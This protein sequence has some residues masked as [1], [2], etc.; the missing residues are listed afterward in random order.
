MERTPEAVAAVFQGESLTYRELNEKANRLAHHMRALGIGAEDRV[1]FCLERSPRLLVA[2][3]AVMKSG[4]TYVPL[5]PKHP[6]ERL[7]YVL[8][9]TRAAVLLTES[10]VADLLEGLLPE[11]T[12][13]V[14]LDRDH[15]E[16]AAAS[17][18]NPV[19]LP[20]PAERL[21]YIIYT[22]GST[23][24]PKGVQVPHR[25]LVNFLESMG[26]SPG[27]SPEDTLLA[28]TTLSFDMA[29]PEVLLP[30]VT[31]GRIAIA[32]AEVVADGKALAA[33]LES[34]GATVLQAT[35]TTW[36]LLMEAGWEGTPGLRG[37]IGAEAVLR[38]VAD[39]ILDR[40]VE[41]W[42]FYGPTETTVWSTFTR[43]ERA[44]GTVPLGDP[45]AN[46]QVYVLD[47][48]LHQVP[49]GVPGELYIG[50]AG[51]TRGYFGQPGLTAERYLP[52]P[53]TSAQG[54]RLYRT[55]D[56]VRRRS[57]GTLE[58][59][60]RT[61]FQVKIRGFRIEL[62]EIEAVLSSHPGVSQAAVIVR[63]DDP[64]GQRLVAY[65]VPAG[66]VSAG[67]LRD[68]LRGHLEARLPGYMVPS[69]FVALE[70]LPL[71]PNGKVDR[72]AL[73]ALGSAVPLG[74]EFVA[75]RTPAEEL[76]AALWVPLLSVAQVGAHDDFFRLGGHSLLAT[77]LVS[78]IR[79]TFGVELALRRIFERPVL[80]DLAVEIERGGRGQDVPPLVPAG[81][82][83]SGENDLPLSFAQERLWF[84]DQFQPGSAAYNMPAAVRLRGDLDVP[85]FR[86]SLREV[87]RR[88]ESLRTT[89]GVGGGGNG[90][91]V[92]VIAAEPRLEIP[93]VDLRA[94]PAAQRE[95]TVRRLAAEEAGYSFDLAEGPLLRV[96]LLRGDGEWIVLLTMHH[97]VSD[98]WSVNVLIREIAALYGAF[99]AGRPSP[100]AELP[101]QYADFAQWQ[102]GWLA[103]EVLE[104]QIEY[105]RRRLRGAPPLLELP[106][107]RP[108]PAVQSQ[109]GRQHPWAVPADVGEALAALCRSEGATLFMGL[110]A[111]FQGLLQRYTGREDV[112]VG[113]PVAGRNRLE[114]EGLIGLF[115]NSL[116]LRVDLSGNPDFG[117]RLARTRE[118]TLGAYAHQ[119]VPFEKLVQELAPERNMSHSPLFQVMLVLQN[120]PDEPL[121]MAGMTLEPVVAGEDGIEEDIA[122]KLDLTLSMTKTP[123]GLA[124][125]V[126][127]N[128]D[129]FDAATLSRLLGHFEV[130]LRGMVE[131]PD[132]SPLELPLLTAAE[133]AQ[134]LEWNDTVVS[135]PEDIPVHRLF[136][137]RV[138][139]AP[140]R[141]AVVFQEAALTYR[142]LNERAN[143][144]AHAL[145]SGG[146]G[147]E[148]RVGICVERSLEMVVAVLGV[149]KAGGAYVPLDPSHPRERLAWVLRDAGARVLLT[150][151]GVAQRLP[152]LLGEVERVI[153]L[154]GD[155]EEISRFPAENPAGLPL[156]QGL[157]YVIYT[158]G[159]TGQPKG[160]QIPHRALVNFLASMARRP[161]LTEDDAVLAVTTL[162]FDIAGLE[163]LLPLLAGGRVIVAPA[164][165]TGDGVALARLL[166]DSGATV[167]QATPATWR[168]LLES[169]WEGEPDLRVLCGG[170]ALPR[171]LAG[172]LLDKVE[173]LWN[174]YGPTETTVWS[175]AGLVERGEGPVPLGA[176]IA[177]T[178]LH[179]LDA[180]GQPVPA[181]VPGE[182]FIGGDGLAR[183][184]LGRPALTAER[185]VPDPFASARGT[186]G[187]RMYR[188]GDLVRRRAG[189][190][191]E[192]LG[193]TDF[194]VKIRGFRI[195]LG[196]VEAVLAALPGVREAVVVVRSDGSVRSDRSS[197]GQRLVAYVVG[198]VSAGELRGHVE[199]YLPGYMV[200][201]VF[202]TLEALPL[203]PNGKVDRKALP[204]PDDGALV[205]A[206]SYV[207]PR[208]PTEEKLA[209][210]W[211]GLLSRRPGAGDDFFRIG[212]HSLL[213]TQLVS[214]IREGFGIELPLRQVFERPTLEALALEIEAITGGVTGGGAGGEAAPPLRPV[215]REGDL[216]LSFAQ[217]RLWFLDQLQPGSHAYNMPAAVRLHGRLDTGAFLSTLR[218]IAR[219]HE[220]LRTRFA[221]RGGRT[222]QVIAAEPDLEMPV[223]DLRALPA[224]WREAAVRLLAEE[225]RRRTFDLAAGP[226]IR[227]TLLRLGE[228]EHAGLLTLHHIVSDGWS[229]G[230][231]IREIAALYT[232][233]TTGR[234]SPLPELPIQYA[235]FAVWQRE[236][237][238]GEVLEA[239]LAWWRRVLAGHSTLQLP[240]DRPR[241]AIQR[242]NGAAERLA[243]GRVA[244]QA[245]L[246]L[247]ARQ[248]LTSYMTMLAGF[249][250]LLYR[251]SEQDD[252]VIGATVAGRDRGE[253]EP[254]I[255][256]FVNTLP[257][258]AVLSGRPS[259]RELFA[260]VRETTLGALSHQHL[261][262]EKL[263][264]ELAPA[265]G[266]SR[267][268]IFQV[269]FQLHNDGAESLELPG[270]VLSPVEAG[271]QTAKFDIVLNLQET[272][273][274]LQG[275]WSYN[276]DLF[277]RATLARMSGHFETLIAG[278]VAHPDSPVAELPLL[279]GAER[280][281][282]DTLPVTAHGKVDI[283]ADLASRLGSLSPSKRELLLRRL[284]ERPTSGRADRI[285]PVPRP[286]P[287]GEAGLPLSF[288]QQRLW[289][290][291][292]LQPGSAAYNVPAA[293]RL[294]GRLDVAA[295]YRT[296]REIVRRHEVLRTSFAVQAGQP[297][298]V[299]APAVELPLFVADLSGLAPDR[300]EA[301]LQ[302]LSVEE[303]VL[304]FDLRRAPLLR[305]TLARL[306]EGEHTLLLTLHH[307]ISDGW[308]FGVLVREMAALYRAF[309]KGEPSPLPELPVQYAD[310]AV[311]Q[312][313]WL[314]GEVLETQ[315][316][317][318]RDRLVQAPVLQLATDRPR[319]ALASYRGA[320]R[321][322]ALAAG[323]SEALRALSREQGATPFMTFLAGF[324]ALLHRYTS[325]DDLIVGSTIANRVRRELE[326]LIG[327]F[328][329]SLALRTDL[330]GDPSF[331]G[332]VVRAREVALGAYAHQD[333]PFEKLVADLQPERDQSRSPLFQVLCQLQ[334][335]PLGP[336]EL[337]AL[338]MTPMAVSV[339]TA[340]FDLVLNL[341]EEGPVFKG[342]LRYDTGLFQ[343]PTA[344]RIVRHLEAL[345]AGA[346]AEPSR[347]LSELALLSPAERQQLVLEW[348]EAPAERLG[349]VPLHEL[350][351]LQAARAPETVAV[352]SDG[353]R[354]SYGELDRRANRLAWHLAG[355]GVCPGDLVGLCLERSLDMV[356][357]ILGVLKA[358]GAYVPL[359]PTYPRERLAFLLE[360]SR[361]PVLLAQESL[362][363][364]LPEPCPGTRVVFL[365]RIAGESAEPPAIAVSA[366][367]PAYVIYTSGS[368][369]KPK[370][371]VVRHGNVTRL[372]SATDPWFGFGPEDV[373]T[374]FHSYAFDFSVWEIWGALLYGGRLVVVPWA[375]SRSPE[376]FYELL[377]AER[378]TVLNQTPSAFRQLIWAE[379]SAL[380]GNAPDLALRYVIFGGEAL[381]PASLALWFERHG[382]E[383]PRLINMYG[384][385]ETTVH[386]TWRPIER[387]D[388]NGSGSVIGRAIPDLGL[389][390]LDGAFQPQ[391]VGVP[392]EIH[393]GGAGLALGYL[394][395]PELTAERFV[396]NPF[397]EPGSR[398]YRS[399][400]LARRLADGDLEYLGRID[401]Q[402]KIRGFRIELG[403]IESA[404]A[405]LPVVR[406][407]VVLARSDGSVR[408]DRSD[409]SPGERQLVAYVVA[410]G[411]APGLT[412]LRS[413]LAGILPDYMLPSALV[414]LDALPVTAHGKVDRRA[415]PSPAVERPDL[416]GYVAPR[417]TLESF[418][419]GLWQ[420]VLGLTRIGVR[421]DFFGL[422]GNSISGAVL[423][424]RLQQ[425]LAEI[426]HVVVIFDHP[427]VESLATYLAEQHGAAVIRRLGPDA[428]AL[429]LAAA[430]RSERI[431]EDDLARFRAL[432]TPLAPLA[433]REKNRRAVF[434][435]SPPRSGSTLLRVMLGGHPKLFAPPELEL[436]GF[437]TLAERRAA[438]PGRDSFWLE[439]AIRAVMEIHGCGPEEA[440]ER[441]E[442]LERQGLTTASFY[443]RLQD[444]L[445]DLGDLGDRILVDKTP[446]Y[447]LD[448]RV[449]RRAEEIFAEPFYIHLIRHPYGM[450]RSFEE[451]RLDQLFFRR[452]H[453][454]SRRELA[455]LIWLASHENIEAFLREIPASRQHW[456]RFEE[457]VADPEGAL[458]GLCASLG[459]EY[460]PDMAE[461]YTER[462][463]RMTDGLHA[464]SRML[465][466]VKFHQHSGVDRETA[467][468]WRERY[469]ED[470]LGDL[471]WE[472]AGRLGY[473][474]E[475]FQ[476]TKALEVPPLVRAGREGTLP[477]SFAQ[478][479]LWFL[480]QLDPGSPAYNI[481][482]ALR[483]EGRLEIAALEATLGEVVRRHEVLRTT[484]AF[485]DDGREP[486][487]VIHPPRSAGLSVTDLSGL[488]G[489]DREAA[490]MRLALDDLRQPF[491]LD[492]GPLLR[493]TLLRLGEQEHI[494]LFSM[495]H[496]VSDG[497]SMG[498]LV[499][500][501]GN[502]YR[503][504][505]LGQA[506]PLRELPIQYADYAVWQRSWLRGEVLAE[507]VAYWRERLAGAPA[508]LRL[509]ADR[510]RPAVQ[511]FRGKRVDAWLPRELQ[512]ALRT[513][514]Q[515]QGAT[516]FMALLAA[517]AILLRRHTGEDD[518][519][520]GTPTA[521]RDRAEL[522]GLIGFFVNTLPLRVALSG[523]PSFED[524]LSR[525]RE[526]AVGA[527]FHQGVPFEKLVEE[528]Q[529][530]RSLSHSPLF[531]VMLVLQNAPAV[532][533]ELPALTLRAED[534]PQEI[535][536]FDLT[537]TVNET[538]AGLLCQWQY[539]SE[540]FDPAT[541][542]RMAE[543]MRLVVE[544]VA[545]EPGR[546]ISEIPLLTS[547]ER[548]QLLED[549][550]RGEAVQPG[551]RGLHEMVEAQAERRPEAPAV[552][553]DGGELSYAELNGRS[554]R[555]ARRLRRLGVGPEV[556]VGLCAERSPELVVGLIAVLK[557]GGAYVPLD[558]AYP[559]ERLAWLLEDS[560]VPVLL[561]QEHR[562]ADLPPH[563]AQVV[564]L[565]E[566]PLESAHNLRFV[567]V[568]EHLA[569]MIYTSGSTG[570]PKGVLVSHRGLDNLAEAQ[571]RLF[572]V[573]PDSRVLQFASLSFD[574]SVSELAMAFHAGA[575]LCLAPR[576]ELLPGLELIE[577]LRRERIT[578]VTL[579]PSVLAALPEA[580]LPDLRT[581]VVAGEAC[582][583]DLARR[584]SAGRRLINAYG[585]TEVTVCATAGLYDGGGRLPVGRPIQNVEAYVIDPEGHLSL[586]GVPG[587]LLVGGAGLARGYRGRPG[588]TAERFVPHPFSQ[589][590]GERL[591]RT[592]DLVR[593]L[594][595]GD[596]GELEFLGRIDHQ[597]KVRGVRV[598]PGEVEAA[599][600]AQPG[601]REAVAVAR[602][603][604]AGPVRLVAYVVPAA[605]ASL[606]PAALRNALAGT[607]PEPLVPA[608]VAVLEALP[609]TPSGKV[610]RQALPAPDGTRGEAG[611]YV[612]PRTDLER[613]LAGLW[614]EVL[615]A[616]RVG[617]H[618][619]FF[620][621]GGNSITGAMFV[622]RLQRELGEIVHVVVMFDAPTVGQLA[623]WVVENY[624]EA[625]V[626]LFGPEALGEAHR[627]AGTAR[628]DAARVAAFRA[629][630]PP[631]LPLSG[632]VE[633]NPPAVFV[634]SPPRSG[635]T[636]LRVLLGGNPRLFAPPEL[637]LLPFDTLAER[638]AAFPGRDSFWL[639]GVT[640]AVMEVMEVM[641]VRGCTAEEAEAL[642]EEME[643]GGGTTRELYRRLQSWIGERTLVDKTPSYA[644]DLAVLRRAEETFENAR[645]IHLLRHPYGMIRSFE[646]AKLE[647]VFF[648]HPHSLSRRELAELIWLVSQQNILGFL[649]EV[650][651]ERQTRVRFE[652]LL[653]EP[654]AV[655]RGLSDFLGVEYHPDMAAPYKET[656]ARMTDGIHSWSRM[657]GDVKFHQHAGIDPAVG[658]RWR[659]LAAED[660]LGD[661]TWEM[662]ERLGYLRELS[663][664]RERPGSGEAGEIPRLPRDG[665][666]FPASASQ[667]REWVLDRLQP[668]TGAYNIRG[669]GKVVG[670]AGLAVLERSLQEIVRRHE[671][672]RTTFTV[673]ADGEPVQ[674][675]APELRISVPVVDL[676]AL[677]EEPRQAEARRV[678][679]I[680]WN[681]PFDL[682]R[683]PLMRVKIVRLSGREHLLLITFHHI[684]SDGWSTMILYRE[685]AALYEA[686][687][688]GKPSPLPEL[689]IQYADFAA[690]QRRRL[691]GEGLAKQVDYWRR[692]LAGVPPLELPTDR[693]RPPVQRFEGGRV[694]FHL[695]PEPAAGLRAIAQGQGQRQGASL[696][697]ALL[698]AYAALLG[699]YSGQDD[700]SVGSY[701]GNRGRTELEGLIGFF[702]NS[703]VLRLKLAGGPGFRQLLDRAR[704]VTLGAFAHQEVPF[705]KLLEALRVE[706]DL[707]RTPL[708]QVMLVLHNFPRAALDLGG[709]RLETIP[710]DQGRADFDLTLWLLE[711]GAGGLDGAFTYSA[712]LFEEATIARLGGHLATLI[713]AALAEPD[714]SVHELPLLGDGER[715]QILTEWSVGPA[716]GERE[717]CL[718]ELFE[719]QARRAP[720]AIAVEHGGETLTYEELNRRADRLAAHLRGLGV[721]PEVLAGLAV[722]RSPEMVV[723]M[724]AV[725]KAGG[726]YLPLDPAYPE[727]RRA[728]M[729]E[730]SRA[731]VVLTAGK[732]SKDTK[733]GESSISLLSLRSLASFGSL[734]SPQPAQPA[735]TAYVIYTSGSTG[736]PKGVVVE[737]R[738][739]AAYT[740]GAAAAFG[741][742]REDRVLQFA[743]I[744]FDTSGE[745]IY[746]TL[747][748]GAT[749][750]LRPEDMALSIAHFL[751]EVARLRITVLDL[752]TAYWHELAAGLGREGTL[753]DCVRL[754]ILGGEKALPDR[755]ALW[756]EKVGPGV[757]LLNTYGPTEATIV[758]SRCDLTRG[759]VEAPIGRPIPGARAFVLD[760]GGEPVPAG[761]PGELYIGGSGLARG[762]L[763][764]PEITAERF[765]PDPFA[766]A[767]GERLYRTGDRVRW[768]PDGELEF[769]GRVDHQVKLRGFRVEPGEIEAALRGHPAVHDAAVVLK[770]GP[771]GDPRLV[772]Y[773]VRERTADAP[774]DLKAYLRERLPEFMVPALFVELPALPLTPSGKVDRRA[775]PEPAAARPEAAAYVA[776][777]SELERTIAAVWRDLLGVDRIGVED[778]FFDLG[779]HS[780]LLVRAHA[781]L[782]EALGQELTV[783]DL[784]RHPSVGA[785]ARHLLSQ[786]ERPSFHQVEDLM[787]RQ[788]AGL[789]QRQQALKKLKVMTRGGAKR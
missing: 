659:E 231:L 331:S 787:Q 553:F 718:H 531:Q 560:G 786:E 79:E 515:R 652:E 203:T 54:A 324:A 347:R 533:L 106:T 542:E 160:V 634:L 318:W 355:L 502:L 244:S 662:A 48:A 380:G 375:V 421:D 138:E 494:L 65:V 655:L 463:A 438:F 641:E 657:L 567:N 638:R 493:A 448:P 172:R 73:P 444:W 554:N 547:A 164:E 113:T 754:V 640:R 409:G 512:A 181:G 122:V 278:A 563:G 7:A 202:V 323:T 505:V 673:G 524:L 716:T 35:P 152:D 473:G 23:G 575:A 738:S 262:F 277:E 329:N 633:K 602:E 670:P 111:A 411:A 768:R 243:F 546:R 227:A 291:D 407:A 601:V 294:S 84:L 651:P 510:P 348:N 504:S 97:I 134:L 400:D 373:W 483:L 107:D 396:P 705:E 582:S 539:N 334:N 363:E 361:V 474:R 280:Q 128:R 82:P 383:S 521:N 171:E 47:R 250:A 615:G 344:A 645:Y 450:I 481:S 30:L 17:P 307:I 606:D 27:L 259:F 528:L 596:L 410:E 89:F 206:A 429:D 646:E 760:R 157:A 115:L 517:F 566:V 758:A 205:S 649:A 46:T 658:E 296:L 433:L 698:A 267:S 337:P 368:T 25:A 623:A 193:R 266:L 308:S 314:Q 451:A 664:P 529:P 425:E 557:A 780:L 501:V 397:G 200:P 611:E 404:L 289:F 746:P 736:K 456:V 742:G 72:K 252:V 19:P 532:A 770:P 311:W 437:G 45:F 699:R 64:A 672:L 726:A 472:L 482:V 618:D 221:V 687:M 352:I 464:E 616:G 105:W 593:F 570:T 568:P 382:D 548:L 583:V 124:G 98:G 690:W 159:S 315:L 52:D 747:A 744:S 283:P 470:F 398:L 668:G 660:F 627:Q 351:A 756:R 185:F 217:Q 647:Q 327:F 769:L 191:L 711:D 629:L 349:G 149:L 312:R 366:E 788:R 10:R 139:Q 537:L 75:P 102:R 220:S 559:R 99:V 151:D 487:Q 365:D 497:W 284:L 761:V 269:V 350:F 335:A 766:G 412:D 258:R 216:P 374:L 80:A 88:H 523:H 272:A 125:G 233:F 573:G 340:K 58:F 395:R 491:D 434:V 156:P 306:E 683:G 270:L 18:K 635:S 703:Q 208:T 695:P 686:F 167:M 453:P 561:T 95:R 257:M 667:L 376:A 1:G 301:E 599:L 295:L 503:A 576:R 684:I 130:L 388:V 728:L 276:T 552:I 469:R 435:L 184:Y 179:L 67:D 326:G 591:Y 39:R 440:R 136:E 28:I 604:G 319:T 131:R 265:R 741:L 175:T 392:G 745:E 753:P 165:V 370:G 121:D 743:S 577:L 613:F 310:F 679:G 255:G 622:N 109:R 719:E 639:E 154:D 625:V 543:R 153:R 595:G 751:R 739:I 176:P 704:E 782:R 446:S 218:E 264:E 309:V 605:G 722:E 685:L 169:G 141:T 242:F 389:Y 579:P 177:N 708:F 637:E 748:S 182:L 144:L 66:S 108:R 717:R 330:S 321:P 245:F 186:P 120:A 251:Y 721:G 428:A 442:E 642:L 133:E 15:E 303:S 371:V 247:G 379:E 132:L 51:V 417:D 333:L 148:E 418:V 90:R 581:I 29:V 632:P 399:G 710:V 207:A 697:M 488:P 586:P 549:W 26:R 358:G 219:R 544:G 357:A 661:V 514:G 597:I 677:A 509:P 585:P 359:D 387:Q 60:G 341:W 263:V 195:E 643:R 731:A 416:E 689:P 119:D 127:Y 49:A 460:H 436:L 126:E 116:V 752:P 619:N 50:G 776:P 653:A 476:I 110:M 87:V 3:L 78:R 458:R 146:F 293:V 166:K 11:S 273:G 254:L 772:A 498:V 534:R 300:R 617:V 426:V 201:S 211:A 445:G 624:P 62:G 702:I 447:A 158:S 253:L 441:M 674:V 5:D 715:R 449:L 40:G 424:N 676:S 680:E 249:Q 161:G 2:V 150:G 630:I 707:S 325:Q 209:E 34:S 506:A 381:E 343:A 83:V 466:D 228:D 526:T 77:Q 462:S 631:P 143:R 199:T 377:R 268:P 522:E 194:Q 692:Q 235:D 603:D 401:H 100:L 223:V 53:F 468:R 712:A 44:E 669:G 621:L 261:P 338:A 43:V 234:P 511:R 551:T 415:L 112:I 492:C 198:N 666:H 168:L 720:A 789:G 781:R 414:L 774:A 656:S 147:A 671:S 93:E 737:H 24:R 170:E 163:L 91:P 454:F 713:G 477:L 225:E 500:E 86:R 740:A 459:I 478:Q 538:P 36:R 345:L 42:T 367:H 287:W 212:G 360:D 117:Q 587:E 224:E 162:S 12:A 507:Q 771:G 636:L 274:G 336:V 155:R 508:L 479:R 260:Q 20:D 256:F 765:V 285:P 516:L 173:S 353:E 94:L 530:E 556:L 565:D 137:E 394:E 320:T 204:A 730:D 16:I 578:T 305:A 714:R 92:Q 723:A 178:R 183:S 431:G 735:N 85:A 749:L 402:V 31:G 196:E 486:V 628:V 372:F 648:R 135:F 590:P 292:Q 580:A 777:K 700:L 592:G 696:F 188:T 663:E 644:L 755:L 465:G 763:D 783:I 279:T 569:Y 727:A 513:S 304:A 239:Q 232:A 222:V 764:R 369:G 762:Y 484:F 609:L 215:S 688:A 452:E 362:A 729:L 197:G 140:D 237:L 226:L 485:A 430:G 174:L 213:A 574:A 571:T 694:S 192:F 142:E 56:L 339:Q 4:G 650:P 607:L 38:E 535:S 701:N 589:A 32:P 145:R 706:R 240:T 682:E 356:V 422:G 457:L 759:P 59:L 419:A 750:V 608:A 733:D 288:A 364:V 612:A 471:T 299:I 499:R 784:F 779:A 390:V 413:A 281:Q 354:L 55:G 101:V 558:P 678:S 14:L 57:G 545:A 214:R 475:P 461:P 282:L 248:G 600:L 63:R 180:A 123:R 594:P 286:V 76:L 495:H 584:W 626:R 74:A 536:K 775:L 691:A 241:P 61:D 298:Q 21:A 271:G 665:N 378:V 588:L 391:P 408:S 598:E 13:A 681:S 725:L 129:L 316:A 724:L 328:V 420:E 70:A 423:I 525:V 614:Q 187:A 527:Y 490:A 332:L 734:G 443:G 384:I 518:V 275:A 190:A 346:V 489:P 555:L 654:E 37:F 610:D 236:W 405:A 9:D 550:S 403:E 342:E 480:N 541:V 406:E 757:R 467:E 22:S 81:R 8:S 732:D 229:I 432:I 540:L 302:I 41:L 778:N 238:Q 104:E 773:T 96:A 393:V 386:V 230:V 519:V 210:I 767:P 322:L 103:G 439:G 290:I 675:V 693:P 455:E 562:R 520:V 385:T 114:T 496:I 69:A 317:Y 313:G 246:D 620:A 189:G 564:L 6:R 71:T 572:E 118:V 427:T 709:V 33:L 297:V 785:L 68:H